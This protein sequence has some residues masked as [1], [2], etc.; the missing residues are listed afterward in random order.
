MRSKLPLE[1]V[2]K[3]PGKGKSGG[4]NPNE[5]CIIVV[6]PHTSRGESCYMLFSLTNSP[7]LHNNNNTTGVLLGVLFAFFL[8]RPCAVI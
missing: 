8:L 7:F 4:W 1:T 2:R 5:S 3:Q 6:N